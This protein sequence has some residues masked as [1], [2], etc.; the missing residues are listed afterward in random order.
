MILSWIDEEIGHVWTLGVK[1]CID[2]LHKA[3]VPV[4]LKPN[5]DDEAYLDSLRELAR[6]LAW[7]KEKVESCQSPKDK[8][9]GCP[10]QMTHMSLHDG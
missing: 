5:P 8:A 9:H 3:L 4:M 1:L 10:L 6:A 7:C 2:L